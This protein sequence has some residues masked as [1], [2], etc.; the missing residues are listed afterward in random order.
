[1]T[2][3]SVW[4]VYGG[5]TSQMKSPPGLYNII[6]DIMRE[7]SG[8]N[9]LTKRENTGRGFAPFRQLMPPRSPIRIIR[10]L[11]YNARL[12]SGLLG[13]NKIGTYP[14]AACRTLLFSF[15]LKKVLYNLKSWTWITNTAI[16][17]PRRVSLLSYDILNNL[18]ITYFK[19]MQFLYTILQKNFPYWMINM[20]LL[21]IL[22]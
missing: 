3:C 2:F 10:V 17:T 13:R 11:Y 12:F 15:C 8:E 1:M 6:R 18:S 7:G 22:L 16:T 14:S 4:Y 5:L 19:N 9:F 21:D 20:K